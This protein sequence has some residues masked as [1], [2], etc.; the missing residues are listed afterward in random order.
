MTDDTRFILV[1]SNSHAQVY[2]NGHTYSLRRKASH[3]KAHVTGRHGEEHRERMLK[4][5][6]LLLGVS[7]TWQ[8]YG[9]PPVTLYDL[10]SFPGSVLARHS[11]G[12]GGCPGCKMRE[13]VI[14]QLWDALQE[15]WI[16]LRSNKFKKLKR[17]AEGVTK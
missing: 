9:D 15:G 12:G 1:T 14:A 2:T 3:W 17:L 4:R 16:D 8:V 10:E 7:L 11:L 6:Q 13:D 5:A